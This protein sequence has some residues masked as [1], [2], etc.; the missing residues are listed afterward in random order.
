MVRTRSYR[1]RRKQSRRQ[2]G[3]VGNL[4]TIY[5]TGILDAGNAD[6]GSIRDIWLNEPVVSYDIFLEG[7]KRSIELAIG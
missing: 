5:T 6:A 2:R 1:R 3:G 4:F 7:F